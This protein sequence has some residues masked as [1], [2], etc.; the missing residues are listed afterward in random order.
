ML[1]GTTGRLAGLRPD[2]HRAATRRSKVN[3]GLVQE[4][5][6]WRID[7]PPPGLMVAEFVVPVLLPGLPAYLYFVSNDSALVPDSIYLPTLRNPANVA[8]AL[9]KALLNGPSDVAG[10]RR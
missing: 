6:E 7:K 8:S 10:P 4:D 5:G 3:F 1:D 2:L 9:M